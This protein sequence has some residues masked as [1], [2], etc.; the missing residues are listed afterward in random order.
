MILIALSGVAVAQTPEIE[1]WSALNGRFPV[2]VSPG[3]MGTIYKGDFRLDRS[4]PRSPGSPGQGRTFLNTYTLRDQSH[5][6]FCPA[7]IKA[8]AVCLLSTVY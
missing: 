5:A 2:P 3:E 4:I 1:E 6:Q 7:K 8:A